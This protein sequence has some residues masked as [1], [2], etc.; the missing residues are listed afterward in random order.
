[1]KTHCE[2]E[3]SLKMKILD[4]EKEI[5]NLTALI[6]LHRYENVAAERTI[7]MPNMDENNINEDYSL[8]ISALGANIKDKE[9]RLNNYKKDWEQHIERFKELN[10]RRENMIQVFYKTG[11]REFFYEHIQALMKNHN[12]KL[13]A[14]ENNFKEKFNMAIIYSKAN[15]IKELENQ[16]KFR[17]EFIKQSGGNILDD[18]RV[19]TLDML[20]CENSNKLPVISNRLAKATDQQISGHNNLPP[21]T[22]TNIN[23]ILNDVKAINNNINRMEKRD[24]SKNQRAE[25]KHVQARNYSQGVRNFNSV[26]LNKENNKDNI[27]QPLMRPNPSAKN[28]QS[29]VSNM[30]LKKVNKDE[31]SDPSDNSIIVEREPN[32][33]DMEHSVDDINIK[34]KVKKS[35]FQQYKEESP[36]PH[37]PRG[38]KVVGILNIKN[39]NAKNDIRNDLFRNDIAPV[40]KRKELNAFLVDRARSHK[41]APF[42][43]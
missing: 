35:A 9:A 28:L 26:L 43:I 33:L 16:I 12:Y 13:S 38:N 31:N 3:I 2:E 1:L 4:E 37:S 40:A 8:N 36:I 14:L 41:K 11:I 23:S 17:D 22:I 39:L 19:K 32:Y 21:I 25:S 10:K 6:A 42:K 18:E 24:R 34:A 5:N 7:S 20:K 15:Y 30:Q 29:K 27:N